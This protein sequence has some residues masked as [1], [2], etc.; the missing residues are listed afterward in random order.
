MG[1]QI[2]RAEEE[3]SKSERFPHGDR[4][5]A[6]AGHCFVFVGNQ[7]L[8]GT[9]QPCIVEAEWPKV[10]LSRV[11]AHADACWAKGQ[12]LTMAQRKSGV[13]AAM[14]LVGRQYDAFAYAYFLAKLAKLTLDKDL[15]SFFQ[16]EAKV[17]PICSG[18]VVR[19]Q[20]A[21]NVPLGPLKTAATQDPDFVC[22][23]DCLRWG[24]DNGWMENPP[25][26]DWK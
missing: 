8:G 21:M 6:W 15:A 20:E 1:T 12:S 13:E 18:V 24:L 7:N 2:R 4:Q 26:P 23:A 25:S 10:V 19:E 3:E 17:G 16:A 5:A 11:T 14:A 22:P 9:F